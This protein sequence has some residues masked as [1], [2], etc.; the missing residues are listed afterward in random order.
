MTSRAATPQKGMTLHILFVRLS[1][2]ACGRLTHPR[3]ARDGDD[4]VDAAETFS[5]NCVSV[6]AELVPLCL[7]A[8]AKQFLE[9]PIN[10]ADRSDRSPGAL[11]PA[12]AMVCHFPSGHERPDG[13]HASAAAGSD[14]DALPTSNGI[15]RVLQRVIETFPTG[16]TTLLAELKERFPHKRKDLEVQRCYLENVL[17]V[18]PS[19]PLSSLVPSLCVM[20]RPNISKEDPR[21]RTLFSSQHI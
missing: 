18:M 20:K 15:H 4:V 2:H 9:I 19:P 21:R 3:C 7:K 1:Y 12:H 6:N 16:T 11:Q 10:P 5:V 13:S 17:R 8:L 14:D